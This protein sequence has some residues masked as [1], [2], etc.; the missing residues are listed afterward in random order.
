MTYGVVLG[1]NQKLVWRD[2]TE[3][4]VR[5]L[6]EVEA[7]TDGDTVDIHIGDM[8]YVTNGVHHL[9]SLS[10][11]EPDYV[12]GA[13]AGLSIAAQ[14]NDNAA[15]VVSSATL[16]SLPSPTAFDVTHVIDIAELAAGDWIDIF[17]MGRILSVNGTDDHT[18]ELR[19]DGDVI[20]Q[21][22][23]AAPV[24]G[25][26]QIEARVQVRTTTTYV[27]AG[28]GWQGAVRTFPT[29]G[30]NVILYDRIVET[31]FTNPTIASTIDVLC[32]HA[33]SHADNQSTLDMLT[34][35][36]HRNG[37]A[38]M[39]GLVNE[40]RTDT[41]SLNL[42]GED[43]VR[44]KRAVAIAIDADADIAPT[45]DATTGGVAASLN[46]VFFNGLPRF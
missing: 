1:T 27:A 22:T 15:S 21:I 13:T 5:I 10:L 38:G 44:S 40:L 32:T 9:E 39:Q 36:I 28:S 33:A 23:S 7:L 24:A 14:P 45:R 2:D 19:F 43:L 30:A 17:A 4:P 18:Y 6:G 37:A 20:T 29:T 26:W 31:A 42:I 16:T 46:T 3:M 41:T 11:T 25:M 34:V 12:T 8:L 35:D